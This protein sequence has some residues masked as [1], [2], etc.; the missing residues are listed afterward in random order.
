[1]IDE[2]LPVEA[3]WLAATLGAPLSGDATARAGRCETDSRNAGAGSVF[4]A[5]RGERVDGHD[6]IETA[7]KAGSRIVLAGET[8]WRERA[9]RLNPALAA[10][11]AA[12]VLV[13]DPLAALQKAGAAWRGRFP[14]LERV[15][16]TGS[17]GKTTT[18]ECLASI[19]SR[20][21]RTVWNP[22]NLNSEIGLPASMFLLRE[23]HEVG[24]FEMGI[25]HPG[26]MEALAAVWAPRVVAV[27]NIG[28]AHIGILGSRQRIAEE[29][30]RAF[31]KF[32]ADGLA[33]VWED[34]DFRDFL[35]KDVPG[36]VAFFGPRS[37]A[38]FDGATELGLEGWRISWR[39][40]GFRFP[41][42]G[43]HNL[44]DAVAAAE[45]A[46][47]LG[48]APADI[49]EGLAS[50]KPL[51]GRSEIVR[52]TSTVLVDC[53]N[54]NPDSAVKAMELCDG[55]E[56]KGRRV[57]VLGAMLELGEGSA[58][59]HRA[60]GFAAARSKADAILVFGEEARPIY[61]AAREAGF[62]GALEFA[63]RFDEL[64]AAARRSS[65]EGDLVL[66]KASRGMALER[67]VPVIAPGSPSRAGH[68]QEDRHVP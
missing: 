15:G 18:K 17:S 21:R 46:E 39:G 23:S 32:G 64:E 20:F 55:V 60:V 8:S 35:A 27:T 24:V 33:L 38:G 14:G 48:A 42:P 3:S 28:T 61:D 66:L 11:G 56:W 37:S 10:V 4:V 62:G 65:R 2:S 36:T 6:F 49:A 1:M 40:V 67:L 54:S 57:Y 26:E 29:K 19:M 12:A 58:E 52:G 25:N 16:V 63:E 59:A 30:K 41:L 34:D 47:R 50:V 44:L 7:I 5:L 31:S 43:R 45:A 13:P 9:S 53:Y 68:G 51:F 22:G